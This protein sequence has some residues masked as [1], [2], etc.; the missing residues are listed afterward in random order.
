MGCGLRCPQSEEY[1]E[2]T[3]QFLAHYFPQYPI[4]VTIGHDD[5]RGIDQTTGCHPHY[6]CQDVTVKQ[7]E[8]D[9]HKRQIQVVNQYVHQIY[10]VE[11]FFPSNGNLTRDE[12]QD[13]GMFFKEWSR[14][15]QMNTCFMQRTKCGICPTHW[16]TAIKAPRK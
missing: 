8:Y 9:L 13:F 10:S 6:F 15:S 14:I 7:V 5:E 4:E 3:R 1:I 2:F 16:S 12:A 11:H